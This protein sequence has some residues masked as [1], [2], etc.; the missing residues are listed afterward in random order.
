[1]LKHMT[2]FCLTRRTMVLVM[3]VA[4]LGAGAL[5][6]SRLNIEAYPDPSTPMLEI[7]TQ[8]P[9]QSAEEI[10]RYIKEN[11]GHNDGQ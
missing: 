5:A 6:F 3:L 7:I 10:E 9:G 4:F 8:S 1:M 11:R 2:E